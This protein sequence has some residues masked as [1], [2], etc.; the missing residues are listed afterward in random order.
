SRSYVRLS[1]VSARVS[2]TPGASGF[3]PAWDAWRPIFQCSRSTSFREPSNGPGQHP[4]PV[5]VA[6]SSTSSLPEAFYLALSSLRVLD[7]SA[8]QQPGFSS[9]PRRRDCGLTT[10]CSRRPSA[11]ADTDR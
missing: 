10:V 1:R 8:E 2:P 7:S 4:L 5:L 3:G 6:A 11:A 9:P